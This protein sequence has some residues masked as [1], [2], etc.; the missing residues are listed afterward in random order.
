MKQ[1]LFILLLTGSIFQSCTEELHEPVNEGGDAPAPVLNPVAQSLPGGAQ[2]TYQLQ[3]DKNFLYVKA[4]TQIREGV[5]REVKASFYTSSLVIDGFADTT[6]YTV[7]LYS[8]GR[9]NKE[10]EGVPVRVKPGI[11][12]V[13]TVLKSIKES[14]QETFGGIKFRMDNPAEADIRIQVSTPDSLDKMILA[15]AFYT[16]V[17]ADEF[18]VRGYDS[19]PRLFSFDVQDRWGNTVVFDSIF[20]PWYEEK[21]DKKKFASFELPGDM[22][23]TTASGN[24]RY[25]EY[26]WDDDITNDSR[27]FQ[28]TGT[29]G[30]LLPHT[31]TFDLGVKAR[32]S[33]VLVTGRVVYGSSHSN[34]QSY[35]YNAGM[36]KEWRIFGSNEPNP[37]GSWDDSWVPLRET[38]CVSFKPSGLPLG[39][40]S[41]E[42]Y[43][44]QLNGEEFEFDNNEPVRYLRWSIDQVWGGGSYSFFNI[45]E[46]TVY[47]EVVEEYR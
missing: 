40:F 45:T 22:N 47:G 7:Y 33:R 43:Q 3:E 15:N 13:W 10:S 32:L 39:D 37:D 36:P 25:I 29:T 24:T 38:P 9:N 18:S 6:E 30:K 17:P 8:V 46:I 34:Q 2:I 28:T 41:D 21:L 44:R 16:S 4:Q 31:F 27:I 26:A 19:I 11:P 5:P 1:Y 20:S 14:V 42:D 23:R 35:V 12:P